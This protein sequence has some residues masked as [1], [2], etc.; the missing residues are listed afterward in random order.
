MKVLSF[1]ILPKLYFYPD[2]RILQMAIKSNIP[3]LHF[4]ESFRL[5]VL[6]GTRL[7]LDIEA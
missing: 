1:V 7:G 2:Q 4:N 3:T 5:I 6:S